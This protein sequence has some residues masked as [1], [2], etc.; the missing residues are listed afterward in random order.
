MPVTW[1]IHRGWSEGLAAAYDGGKGTIMR[2]KLIAALLLLT[3]TPALAEADWVEVGKSDDGT[4]TVT[5]YIDR[6]SIRITGPIRRFWQRKD[7]VNGPHGWKQAVT[8]R[9]DNCASGE[10]RQLH[11]TVYYVDGTNE[12]L[13]PKDKPWEYVT[14]DTVG[15]D[16]HE[17]VCK[18]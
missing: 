3:A 4:R 1:S 16:S 7:L 14:P 8:L 15:G 6:S 17:Y 9:E 13:T 12:S 2:S 18:Q 11:L 10:W 5:I